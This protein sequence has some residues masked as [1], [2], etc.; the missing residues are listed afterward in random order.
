L[1]RRLKS[2]GTTADPIDAS[3]GRTIGD[4]GNKVMIIVLRGEM[5]RRGT[6]LVQATNGSTLINRK[7]G[8]IGSKITIIVFLEQMTRRG[9]GVATGIAG[10][11]II[12]Q[13]LEMVVRMSI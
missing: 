11:T 9:T 2:L 4:I 1:K 3:L 13:K 8:D 5:K 6:G 10:S 12:N 7:T